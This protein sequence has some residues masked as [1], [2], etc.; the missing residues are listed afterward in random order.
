[1]SRVRESSGRCFLAKSA[2]AVMLAEAEASAPNET[3]GVLLG[4]SSP[5]EVWIDHAIGPG[6]N[7]V[8]KPKS[9][10]PDA[11][12]H[13]EQIASLYETTNRRVEYLGDWHTHPGMVAYLSNVDLKTLRGIAQFQ[14]SRQSRPVMAIL[15]DGNPWHLA[16]WRLSS[17]R[18][19]LR[20][21]P[22]PLA[23]VIG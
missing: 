22:H 5:A 17:T 20:R 18:F 4:V 13:R 2:I 8:H 19:R 11:E 6:P 9:F 16:V 1:M 15:G 14:G 21:D 7:A 3:G 12:Y 23:I 10:I